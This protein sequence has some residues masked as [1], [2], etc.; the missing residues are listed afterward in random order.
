MVNRY[1]NVM[2][3]LTDH[4]GKAIDDTAAVA[5]MYNLLKEEVDVIISIMIFRLHAFQFFSTFRSLSY[6]HFQAAQNLTL[7]R[8]TENIFPNPMKEIIRLDFK[9]R[10]YTTTLK[11]L[12]GGWYTH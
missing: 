6:N 7:P 1:K 4:S 8:W 5:H 3:Y 9:L 12:N 2:D 10:S 11:R